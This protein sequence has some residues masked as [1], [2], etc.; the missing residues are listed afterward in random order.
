MTDGPVRNAV[1][2]L[3]RRSVFELVGSGS[4]VASGVSRVERGA[5]GRVSNE[6]YIS[7][8]RL[9][10][11]ATGG[12]FVAAN[13]HLLPTIDRA[14]HPDRSKPARLRIYDQEV[15]HLLQLVDRV[16]SGGPVIV[17]MDGNID[18]RADGRVKDPRW[19][20]VRMG[21]HGL[22]SSWRLLGYPTGG[23]HE[24]RLIDY[25]WATTSTIRPIGQRI[26]GK[27]GSDHSA[28]AVTLT[29]RTAAANAAVT[30]DLQSGAGT[31]T[32]ALPAKITCQAP[33]RGPH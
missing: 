3:W 24:R 13:T 25:V 14:G 21:R 33:S 26:L 6:R 2:I 7:W 32:G 16:K 5:D 29:N 17:T 1:P 23:T 28:V 8:V 18:A 19:P 31:T 12:V 11:K 30:A 27:Y 22:S 20:Q 15:S 10:Q 4:E 9:R